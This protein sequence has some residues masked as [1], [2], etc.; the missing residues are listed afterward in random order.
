MHHIK[1]AQSFEDMRTINNITYPTFHKAAEHLGLCESDDEWVQ[2]LSE[3]SLLKTG[4]QL[5]EL[6]VTILVLNMTNDPGKLW[7]DFKNAFIDDLFF[8]KNISIEYAENSAIIHIDTVLK[9]HNHN[10]SNFTGLPIPNYANHFINSLIEDELRFDEEQIQNLAK[11]KEMLNNDQLFAYSEIYDAVYNDSDN[12]IFFIDG[13]G[14]TGKTFLYSTLLANIRINSDIAL[15]VASSGIAALLLDKG[16]TA[17]SRFKIPIIVDE[18]STCNIK[19]NSDLAKLI[20][21]AKLCIWDEA[22]MMNKFCFEAVDRTFRD[23]MNIDKIF[24]G[25]VFVFGGDFRQILPVIK[26]GSRADIVQS[27]INRSYIWSFVKKLK[28]TINMR[29]S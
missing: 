16:K 27:S 26:H 7:N 19:K 21:S 8:E 23:I 15:A 11:Q 20:Q 6:F 13:P 24:G 17:H 25:K 1:G 29:Q 4:K 2:C 22:P 5:R 28:L 3:A 14:G 10:I 9:H 18:A 12:K